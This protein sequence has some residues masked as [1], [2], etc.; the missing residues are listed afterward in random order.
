MELNLLF[1]SRRDLSDSDQRVQKS[2]LTAWT[3]FATEDAPGPEEAWPQYRIG[4][5]RI[6][7]LADPVTSARLDGE[8][9]RF[10]TR[11]TGGPGLLEGAD[12]R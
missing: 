9:C 7:V 11:V 10:W 3:H 8:K 6:L 2:L 1:P 5:R 4:D 12:A